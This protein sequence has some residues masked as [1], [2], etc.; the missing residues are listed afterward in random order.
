V[1]EHDDVII[2][3]NYRRAA[4]HTKQGVS[5]FR[6]LRIHAVEGLHEYVTDCLRELVARRG[7]FSILALALVR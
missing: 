1:D 7:E 6:G 2:V 5:L 3:D 4:D